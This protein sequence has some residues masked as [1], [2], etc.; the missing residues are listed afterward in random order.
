[1]KKNPYSAF[2]LVCFLIA[3]RTAQG[4]D[5]AYKY[6]DPAALQHSWTVQSNFGPFVMIGLSER[7]T[8]PADSGYVDSVSILFNGVFDTVHVLLVSDTIV[9]TAADT[10]HFMNEHP[11]APIYASA[12]VSPPFSGDPMM[13]VPFPHV[14]V[15][16]EFH[17]LVAPS[18]YSKVSPH[19]VL[20]G[21]SEAT[22]T[23]T[24]ENSRSGFVKIVILNNQI[25]SAVLD[26]ILIPGD[27]SVIFSNLYITTYASEDPMGATNE[28][29]NIGLVAALLEPLSSATEI[30]AQAESVTIFP[31]PARASIHILS[32]APNS[33]VE[34]LDLLGRTV[35][36]QTLDGNSTIDVSRLEPGRYEAVVHSANGV[37]SAPIVIER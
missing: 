4:Q 31:N 3:F 32:Q 29:R 18:L 5:S 23:R 22:R 33:R 37:T 1:M 36:S 21:D 2:F 26:S 30:A 15:P 19:F 6:Y 12:I 16:K 9:S 8:L 20:V 27:T 28:T 35:L 24:A 10:F 17:I 11:A 7:V 13:T 14:R 25:H 34:L